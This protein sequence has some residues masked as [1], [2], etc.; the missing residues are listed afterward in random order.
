MSIGSTNDS[1]DNISASSS[2]WALLDVLMSHVRMKIDIILVYFTHILHTR[3][4]IIRS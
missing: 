3:E 1:G 4:T 2:Y